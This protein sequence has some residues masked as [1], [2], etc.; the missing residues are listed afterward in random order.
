MADNL[1]D[2]E[3]R[4]LLDLSLTDDAVYLALYTV[5][6]DDA[7][8]GGTEVAGNGYARQPMSMGAAATAAGVT[9]KANDAVITFPAATAAWGTIVAYAVHDAVTAG[10]MRWHRTLTAGEQRSVN[11]GDQYRVGIGALTFQLS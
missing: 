5:A 8:A 2:F 9:T 10:N 11:T 1:T 4:R 7:G 3:E 6:P